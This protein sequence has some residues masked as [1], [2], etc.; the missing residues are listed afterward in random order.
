MEKQRRRTARKGGGETFFRGEKAR[1]EPV[2]PI[3]RAEIIQRCRKKP[4]D[5][6]CAGN[7]LLLMDLMAE[8]HL[9]IK[10]L[11]ELSHVARSMIHDVLSMEAVMTHDTAGKLGRPFGLE[12]IEFHLLGFFT[13]RAEVSP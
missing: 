10:G 12:A 6:L 7:A 1:R 4:H 13:L 2:F 8:H 11:H 3:S 9:T 5:M